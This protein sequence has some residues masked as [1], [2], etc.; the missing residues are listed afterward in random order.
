MGH[1]AHRFRGI[2]TSLTHF[3]LL[4]REKMQSHKPQIASLYGLL[5]LILILFLPFDLLPFI[6]FSSF[7]IF[8]LPLFISLSSFPIL[9]L[10]PFSLFFPSQSYFFPLLPHFYF[11]FPYFLYACL[12]NPFSVSLRSHCS[13]WTRVNCCRYCYFW[14]TDVFL[15]DFY[16][17]CQLLVHRCGMC[18]SNGHISLKCKCAHVRYLFCEIIIVWTVWA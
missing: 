9:L 4:E 5:S 12:K 14:N 1:S 11:Y 13:I 6:P 3:P 8:I 17:P 7:P 15:D 18:I 2:P 10:L 16:H